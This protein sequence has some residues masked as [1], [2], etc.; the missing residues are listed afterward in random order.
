MKKYLIISLVS[1]STIFTYAQLPDAY[2][3]NFEDEV[4]NSA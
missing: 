4:Q 2:S 3:C 1:L